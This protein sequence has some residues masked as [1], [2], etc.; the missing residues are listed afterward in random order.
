ML[1]R[2]ISV[3]FKQLTHS[4]NAVT[5]PLRYVIF[6]VAERMLSCGLH[7]RLSSANMAMPHN[8]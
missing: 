4:H 3:P 6:I 7:L 5:K 8:S 2:E 1:L